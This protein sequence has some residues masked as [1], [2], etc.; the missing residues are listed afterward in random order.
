ML[1]ENW[2]GAKL[3]EDVVRLFLELA[4]CSDLGVTTQYCKLPFFASTQR[5]K[6]SYIIKLFLV[7]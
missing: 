3:L 7:Q 6:C 5:K 1:S 2:S 4:D